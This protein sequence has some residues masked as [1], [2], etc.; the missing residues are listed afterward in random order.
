M[1]RIAADPDVDSL[2]ISL[3][4]PGTYCSSAGRLLKALARS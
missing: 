4:G 3:I 2:A 1:G